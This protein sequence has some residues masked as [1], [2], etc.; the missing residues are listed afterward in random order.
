MPLL[1]LAA[2]P[3]WLTKEG[4]LTLATWG[5]VAATLV[6]SVI[7][8][9]LYFDSRA[10]GKEQR[11]RWERE[12]ESRAK[13]QEARWAREDRL[14]E[15]DAKPKVVV[16][17]AKR[18]GSPEIV[19]RCFNLGNTIFFVDQMIITATSPK[20]SVRTSDLVGPPVLLPGGYFSTTYD[21]EG[22]ITDGFQEANAA[23]TVR[24][25]RGMEQTTPVWFYV[26]PDPA[27]G[28]DWTVGRLADRLPGAIVPQPRSLP[29]GQ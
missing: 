14:R 21:C 7:T 13:E 19:I 18:E 27:H 23:F 1:S 26:N 29:E 12:D 24:G 4:Y 11:A 3:D 2:L 10:K 22:L 8:L 20:R 5:L 28:Y 25:S 9:V 15:E 6:L 16:E 17:L